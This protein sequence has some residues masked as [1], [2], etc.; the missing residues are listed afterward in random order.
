MSD[1]VAIISCTI[2]GA[3]RG[4]EMN[5]S[6]TAVRLQDW[7]KPSTPPSVPVDAEVDVVPDTDTMLR[8]PQ[9]V[10]QERCRK[11]RVVVSAGTQNCEPG[12]QFGIGS[13]PSF[14]FTTPLPAIA[15][16]QYM[17]PW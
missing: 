2:S 11:V 8:L 13:P 14:S 9:E 16:G 10:W 4:E 12:K 5:P 3:V 6:S 17:P 7:N 15:C 1:A